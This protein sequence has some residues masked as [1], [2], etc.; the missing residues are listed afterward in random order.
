MIALASPTCIKNTL[1]ALEY[2]YCRPFYFIFGVMIKSSRVRQKLGS[3]TNI[4]IL[5]PRL[6]LFA[7]VVVV[8]VGL[9]VTVG[10]CPLRQERRNNKHI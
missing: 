4:E 10:G 8:V 6:Q 1:K 2:W 5:S 3:K 9:V 7:V